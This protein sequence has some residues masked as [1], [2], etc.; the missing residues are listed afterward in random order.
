MGCKTIRFMGQWYRFLF[1][2]FL[3]T[4]D[5]LLKIICGQHS[6]QTKNT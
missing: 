1:H 4:C 6:Q 3:T 2:D 5:N